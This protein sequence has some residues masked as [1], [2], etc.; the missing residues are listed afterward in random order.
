MK[1]TYSVS[2]PGA[3]Y[4]SSK[5]FQT[6]SR[7]AQVW[8]L[9]LK[10]AHG[11]QATCLCTGPGLKRLS[12]RHLKDSDRYVLARCANTG[13]EHAFDCRFFSED[14]SRTGLKSYVDGVVVEG[15]DDDVKVRLSQAIKLRKKNDAVEPQVELILDPRKPGRTQRAMTLLGLLHLLWTRSDLNTWVPNMEGKRSDTILQ[16]LLIQTAEHIKTCRM[17]LDRVLLSPARNGSKEATRNVSVLEK[18]KT[19]QYRLIAVG[20]LQPYAGGVDEMSALSLM[21]SAGMPTLYLKSDVW[22]DAQRSFAREIL[23][24]RQGAKTIS[25]AFIGQRHN[26]RY[27]DVLD[28]ALM[29][30]SDMLIP[31]D[32]GLEGTVE[33]MLREQK[34]KFSKPLRFDGDDKT[35][36]DFW[37]KDLDDEYPMEVF[38][39]NTPEYL[40]RKA[41]K[42]TF[43]D[44]EYKARL[45]WWYWDAYQDPAGANIPHLPPA[46]R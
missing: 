14:E 30:V 21:N 32:S 36:P 35:L 17:T 19:L 40:L 44:A 18:A 29:H 13:P 9:L 33:A 34:R 43:Y 16:W 23:A 25:I 11:S 46:T 22:A 8:Q 4:P 2:V 10:K 37:L 24:W 7:H 39:M 5:D 28:M 6:Q 1:E 42:V 3:K 12:I 45:G 27:Y 20:V 38:G 26:S 41:D 15:D 31:L